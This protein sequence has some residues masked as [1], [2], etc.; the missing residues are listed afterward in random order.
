MKNTIRLVSLVLLSLSVG[1]KS[2]EEKRAEREAKQAAHEAKLKEQMHANV[3]ADSP[4]QKIQLGMTEAEVTAILGP[5]TSSDSHMTGKQF[6]PFNFS[7]KDTVRI[8]YYW[9]GLGRVEFSAGSWG[10]RNGAI[11]CCHD[12][13]DPGQRQPKEKDKESAEKK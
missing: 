9:K 12:P 4:L 13:N 3:P 10:Q 11:L 1:C 5:Q 7:G 6:V 8:V 2:A